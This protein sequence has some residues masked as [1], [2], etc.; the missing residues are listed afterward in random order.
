MTTEGSDTLYIP[1]GELSDEI[2]REIYGKLKEKLV[3]RRSDQTDPADQPDFLRETFKLI[4]IE[5]PGLTPRERRERLEKLGLGEE[6]AYTADSRPRGRSRGTVWENAPQSTQSVQLASM[7]NRGPGDNSL[8]TPLR[9]LA[10]RFGREEDAQPGHNYAA[11]RTS[12]ASSPPFPST[13][14]PRSYQREPEGFTY[15][16]LRALEQARYQRER[17]AAEARVAAGQSAVKMN[18]TEAS[19]AVKTDSEDVQQRAA[20]AP[21]V[22]AGIGNRAWMAEDDAVYRPEVPELRILAG[23]EDM[24]L[25]VN[26]VSRQLRTLA[27]KGNVHAGWMI[28]KCIAG[29][30]QLADEIPEDA[31][32]DIG[33]FT[34]YLERVYGLTGLE[35]SNY[36]QNLRQDPGEAMAT[37]L[38][39]VI[40]AISYLEEEEPKLPAEYENVKT[41]R[42][43][44]FR[45]FIQ[46]LSSREVR[47]NITVLE[48]ALTLDQLAD[49]AQRFAYA[50][51]QFAKDTLPT[52]HVFAA[53]RTNDRRSQQGRPRERRGSRNSQ[54][55]SVSSSGSR[56]SR[57]RGSESSDES[58]RS[59]SSDREPSGRKGGRRRSSSPGRDRQNND[60]RKDRRNNRQGRFGG[61]RT[62]WN[63]GRSQ[64][65]PQRY[66]K[67]VQFTAKKRPDGDQNRTQRK[68]GQQQSQQQKKPVTCW[69][70]GKKGH[71]SYDCRTNPKFLGDQKKIWENRRQK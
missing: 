26:R 21:P 66:T 54:G 58:G 69:A 33:K 63:R 39:R 27:R 51:R 4:P 15:D 2:A 37:W 19:A 29:Q 9:N 60:W 41:M 8:A 70:C 18:R 38:H 56:G 5:I 71:R 23:R 61:R 55:R 7:S 16:E 30:E 42:R 65:Q 57:G 22:I 47:K 31:L 20:R 25:H 68:N 28:N 40:R 45:I 10:A 14:T 32:F 64:S 1:T 36:V 46:G 11:T 24:A 44:I 6:S 52:R 35:R 48:D 62:S 53:A 43:D 12:N 17:E 50:E 67:K 34:S 13:P 3:V 59:S 49:K